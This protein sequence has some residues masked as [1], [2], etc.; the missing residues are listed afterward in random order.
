MAK[1]NSG[2][3]N[4]CLSKGLLYTGIGVAAAIVVAVI[5]L[6]IIKVTGD[7]D[8]S[9]PV[10]ASANTIEFAENEAARFGDTAFSMEEFILYAIPIYSEYEQIYGKD[11][12]EKQVE[13]NGT[14]MTYEEFAKCDIL[15]T[16]SCVKAL[17][18]KFD[19][20][21]G[22]I[23]ED[24]EQMILESAQ[25]YFD[26]LN[27]AGVDADSIGL[28]TI[29]GH[30]YEAYLAEKEYAFLFGSDADAESDEVI[31]R[32]ADILTAFRGEDYDINK[33]VNWKVVD[34]LSF[35]TANTSYMDAETA[36]DG[37]VTLD[38]DNEETDQ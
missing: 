29:Y 32:M 20:D 19:A 35:S 4:K 14:V 24:E 9:Q 30:M 23:T 28:M 16:A 17:A 1:K 21:G 33:N 25:G 27:E 6:V 15:D 26:S 7:K 13:Y 3:S 18:K 8:D 38:Q 37:A 22:T 34:L 10:Q 31:N 5:V 2:G 12:W 36:I 11:I